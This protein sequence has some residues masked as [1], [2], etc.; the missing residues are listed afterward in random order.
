[1]SVPLSK[2]RINVAAAAIFNEDGKVF[3]SRRPSFVDQ[4]GRWEFPGGKRRPYETGFE[5]LKRELFEELGIQVRRAQPLIRVPYDYGGQIVFLDVWEVRDFSGEPFGREGQ[6]VRWVD[7]EELWHYSFPEAN[8]PIIKS[9]ILPH[10]CLVTGQ[11]SS[12]DAFVESLSEALTTHQIKLVR[13]RAPELSFEAYSQ[14]AAL[15]A[16]LCKTHGAR[17]MLGHRGVEDMQQLVDLS[18]SLDASGIYLTSSQLNA[19]SARPLRDDKWLAATVHNEADLEQAEA[20]G[21]DF[22]TLSPIRPTALCRDQTALGWHDLQ[23]WV[24][25][26]RLPVYAMGGLTMYDMHHAR[27]VGAQGI[28]SCAAFW[29]ER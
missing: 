25:S 12:D 2:R 9:V 20:I 18:E 14:R 6:V 24:R 5:A 19:L 17:I 29:T 11:A 4:G 28:A 21:C 10:T 23:E 7:V 8:V 16:K 15:A 13:V 22:A 27:G 1:M 26:R 3:L